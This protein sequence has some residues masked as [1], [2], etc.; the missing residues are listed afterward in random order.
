MYR[1]MYDLSIDEYLYSRRWARA[2]L[3]RGPSASYSAIKKDSQ[4]ISKATIYNVH[5]SRMVPSRYV[6]PWVRRL[7]FRLGGGGVLMAMVD[8][9]VSRK[10]H[11]D[12]ITKSLVEYE[13]SKEQSSGRGFT[14]VDKK[15]FH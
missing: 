9:F 12:A 3:D 10:K 6:P 14:G 7:G 4:R 15:C 8:P 11:R 5:A 13:Q 1:E 2:S